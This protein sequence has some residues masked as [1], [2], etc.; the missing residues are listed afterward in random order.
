MKQVAGMYSWARQV[1]ADGIQY[2][3]IPQSGN[4]ML[5]LGEGGVGQKK[6]QKY[7]M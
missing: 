7:G 2:F 1:A 4:G 6:Q 3:F 5:D